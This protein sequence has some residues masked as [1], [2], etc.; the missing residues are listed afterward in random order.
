MARRPTSDDERA[1][2]KTALGD[3]KPLRARARVNSPPRAGALPLPP[4]PKPPVYLERS[5]D[6]IGGHR[7]ADLRRGRAEPEA[8]ID[9][10]GM[11]HDG[12]YRALI[13]FLRKAQSDDKRVVLVVTGKGGVLREALPLWLGQARHVLFFASTKSALEIVESALRLTLRKYEVPE[14]RL[15]HVERG[16]VTR[17]M[18]FRRDRSYRDDA[19]LPPVRAP[20]EG[21]SC[22]AKL[23]ALAAFNG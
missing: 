7:A 22:L 8:R 12:A 23:A 11:T 18:R 1:L 16:R 19:V 17:E 15:L 6:P 4:P 5:A 2:F 9:L 20:H 21:A 10:H 14:G 3:A 13:G